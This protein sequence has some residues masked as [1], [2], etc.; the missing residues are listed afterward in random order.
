MK[1]LFKRL[2][3]ASVAILI[4]STITGYFYLRQSLPQLEGTVAA[5]VAAPIRLS[6]DA[7]GSVT[8][9]AK[10][11]A[12]AYF[13]QGFVHAQERFFEMDL[14]RRSG[15]GELAELFGPAALSNDRA[16][17][18]HRLRARL[19]AEYPRLNSVHRTLIERYTDGVNAGLKS[20]YA[21]PWTHALLSAPVREWQPVD[22][23]L[24]NAAMMFN[25]QNHTNLQESINDLAQQSMSTAAYRFFFNRLSNQWDAPL[26]PSTL[27]EF[28]DPP[29]PT[30]AE[31]NLRALPNTELPVASGDH[32]Q[33][34]GSNNWAVAG[35]LTTTGS[36]M[37]AND[38][39]LGVGVPSTWFR[40]QLRY[41]LLIDG[42]LKDWVVTG[43]SLPGAPG[44]VVGS[45]AQVAWGNTNS[46]GDWLDFVRLKA[47][48]D[49]TDQYL[50]ASGPAAIT[51][52]NEVIKVN[53][54]ADI[55]I[56]VRESQYGPITDKD[57][58]GNELALAWVAHRPGGINLEV[59]DFEISINVQELMAHAQR[60]GM[61]QN[62]VVSA[63]RSGNIGWTI[64]GQIPLRAHNFDK[65][66]PVNSEQLSADVWGGFMAASEQLPPS[67]YNP[68]DWRIA[69]ANARVGNANALHFIGNGGYALGARQKRIRDML[70][71]HVGRFTEHDMLS[72]QLDDQAPL[73][74]PWWQ[75]L[76][77]LVAD[78][79]R[80]DGVKQ[81]LQDWQGRAEPESVAYRI[82]RSFRQEISSEMLHNFA[83]PLRAKK[84][85]LVASSSHA[86]V[87]TLPVLAGELPHLLP[88]PYETYEQFKL[89]ALDRALA[90]MLGLSGSPPA[91]TS[92]AEIVLSDAQ[93]S[94]A[95][96]RKH[97]WGEYSTARVQHPLARAIP[98]L[99]WLLDMPNDPV[100]GDSGH[101]VR[102]QAPGFS[103]S[104]RIVVSPGYEE[105]GIFH[106]PGGQSGH[107]LSPYFGAGHV[108]WLQGNAS[109]LLP[110]LAQHTLEIV[111]SN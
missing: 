67:I 98:A 86:E 41:P 77:Q 80:Y 11:R 45:N 39:H 74:N 57:S 24:V 52:F 44:T 110:G 16:H 61:P 50:T 65:Q 51:Q 40:Q 106:M 73:L 32:E 47:I 69:T 63:D 101:V 54:G 97:P 88:K 9:D 83:T 62:N 103:A 93:I 36:A 15:A 59:M 85:D 78:K 4:V 60:A 76:V 33:A 25:L 5:A 6:R 38:M 20:L 18:V 10:S 29:I 79:P 21:K 34:T 30:A 102:A 46:Y 2:S 28:P 105:Q 12:D 35:A 56:T 26:M 13:A 89:T 82:V 94:A 92:F 43:A 3:L 107:P 87:I 68:G 1:K 71:F 58:Q 22:S 53:G 66:V 7:L 81:I 72:M 104:Q 19:S 95:E 70:N 23:L 100:P 84:P 75:M 109:K 27:N 42:E 17:R 91:A 31:F 49:H 55:T 111:P 99:S 90:K 64:G 108:D 8:I 37:L 48:P 14:S 96:L